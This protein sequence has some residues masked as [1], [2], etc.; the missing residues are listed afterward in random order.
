MENPSTK[1]HFFEKISNLKHIQINEHTIMVV[2]A[3]IV[4]LA[5]STIATI[6]S[7]FIGLLSGYIGGN[8]D[9]IL[10]RFVDGAMCIPAIILLMV[11]ISMIGPGIVA[12]IVSL[13]L[14]WGVIGSRIIRSAVIGIKENTYVDAAKVIG[15]LRAR[16]LIRHIL[17]NIMAPT[18][19]LFTT[20]VP[21]VILTEA[22]RGNYF[23]IRGAWRNSSEKEFRLASRS[24]DRTRGRE[25]LPGR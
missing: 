10:Q 3:V 25:N 9:L 1:P 22:A 23:S 7:L 19:I 21:N 24:R 16:L 6:I 11:I 2:L 12:I 14:L 8:F 17:P 4:G 20:R 13:G 18:I 5:A 15:C